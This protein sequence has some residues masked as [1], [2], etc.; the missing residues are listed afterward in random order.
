MIM[1]L[2]N[3]TYK[4]R[5]NPYDI[6]KFATKYLWYLHIY[7]IY[8]FATKYLWIPMSSTSLY[9]N[10]VLYQNFQRLLMLGWGIGRFW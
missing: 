3:T 5:S 2:H 8:D 10:Y 6:Y 1:M 4:C 7:G 9:D